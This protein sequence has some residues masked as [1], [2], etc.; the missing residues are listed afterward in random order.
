MALVT[1]FPDFILRDN[2][3][4]TVFEARTQAARDWIVEHFDIQADPILDDEGT[5]LAIHDLQRNGHEIQDKRYPIDIVV[6]VL[7]PDES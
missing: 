3:Q 6:S 4:G 2:P 7:K 1:K 5:G